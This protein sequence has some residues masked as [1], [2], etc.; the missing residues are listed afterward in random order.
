[1][2]GMLGWGVYD[3]VGMVGCVC[4]VWE[5][6]YNGEWWNSVYVLALTVILNILLIMVIRLLTDVH[7]YIYIYLYI[8]IEKA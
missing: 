1:M 5:Y 7:I 6:G 2:E 8:C 4:G 3:G